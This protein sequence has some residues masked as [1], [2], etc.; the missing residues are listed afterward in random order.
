MDFLKDISPNYSMATYNLMT[1]NCNNFTDICAE[2]LVGEGIPKYIVDLP[3]EAL[4][5][6]MGKQLFGMMNGSQ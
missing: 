4:N 3:Q 2:F 1:N 6:P 5:T